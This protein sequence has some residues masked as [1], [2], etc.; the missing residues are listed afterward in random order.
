MVLH[1]LAHAYHYLVFKDN[2][3]GITAAFKKAKQN[4]LHQDVCHLD[5]SK[6]A[7]YAANDE[8]E[9]FA[10]L[11]EAYFGLNDFFPF[12]RAKLEAHDLDGY[13]LLVKIWG[14]PKEQP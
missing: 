14:E 9:Y 6:R 12:T 4:W 8:G 11:T 1:E 5:G 10:E 3:A 13:Q 7:A 2:H